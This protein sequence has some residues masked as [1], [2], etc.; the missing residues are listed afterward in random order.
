MSPRSMAPVVSVDGICRACDSLR[1]GIDCAKSC[2]SLTVE[3]V[4]LLVDGVRLAADD[5]ERAHSLEDDLRFRVLTEISIG[6]P[7]ARELARVALQTQ[8]INFT[9]WCA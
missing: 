9:R 1:G 5:D 6:S 8:S 7:F 2:D 4:R 3:E